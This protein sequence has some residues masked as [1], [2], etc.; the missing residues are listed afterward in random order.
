MFIKTCILNLS[1]PETDHWSTGTCIC[2]SLTDGVGSQ[3]AGGCAGRDERHH[4]LLHGGVPSCHQLLGLPER[5]AATDQ[6]VHHGDGREQLPRHYEA[7]CAQP[8]GP[9]LR[10]LP[11]HLKKLTRGDG[12]LD[13]TLRW[14][15][16]QQQNE[17]VKS[18]IFTNK[19]LIQL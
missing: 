12:G 16:P 10:Q 2:C 4:R 17:F 7:D 11:L 14:V 9:R 3:P 1:V 8:P 19:N 13:T 5:D 6:Q 18:S 15:L